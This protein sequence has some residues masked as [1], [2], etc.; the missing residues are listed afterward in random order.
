MSH[1]DK[2]QTV[3]T[4]GDKAYSIASA[5]SRCTLH[6]SV[7]T[8]MTVTAAMTEHIENRNENRTAP[9]PAVSLTSDA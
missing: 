2:E 1:G 9:Q 8:S 6:A 7:V 5:Q 3:C 4:D